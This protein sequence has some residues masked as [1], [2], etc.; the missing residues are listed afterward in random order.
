MVYIVMRA[1]ISLGKEDNVCVDS[2]F[3]TEELA[4][5]YID[6][7]NN[8]P[9]YDLVSFWIIGLEPEDKINKKLI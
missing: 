2:V 7:R 4:R 8:D 5:E 1:D 9:M 3:T 6:I